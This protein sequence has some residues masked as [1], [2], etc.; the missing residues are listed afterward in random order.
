[1]KVR[2]SMKNLAV[3]AAL[4]MGA[5]GNARAADEWFL[6]G[7]QKLLATDPSVEIKSEGNRWEKDIKQVKLSVDG[8]DVEI[9]KVVLKWDNREDETLTDIGVLKSQGQTAPHD[10]PGRKGRLVSMKVQYEILGNAPTA[11]LNVWGYD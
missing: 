6:L 2:S 4:L 5:V 1:M 10:S 8:G 9:S 11:T 7:S 3:A